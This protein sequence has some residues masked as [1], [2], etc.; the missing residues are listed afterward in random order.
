MT[1]SV[2]SQVK[3]EGRSR[4]IAALLVREEELTMD[5]TV[6]SVIRARRDHIPVYIRHRKTGELVKRLGIPAKKL[7]DILSTDEGFHKVDSAGASSVRRETKGVVR[8]V[9]GAEQVID[10]KSVPLQQS[11]DQGLQAT[12][13]DGLQTAVIVK[14][15]DQLAVTELA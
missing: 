2:D 10:L 12:R 8:L 4:A 13:D 1:W 3:V 9:Y 5:M 6:D 11:S 14:S 7:A 15:S